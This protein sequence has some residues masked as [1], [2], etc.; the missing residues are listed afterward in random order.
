MRSLRRSLPRPRTTPM[1]TA[2]LTPGEV[3]FLAIKAR[4]LLALRRKQRAIYDLFPD[5]GPLR[6]ELY[7]KHM[8]YF[9]AGALHRERIFMSA[10]RVGKTMAGCYEDAL[11]LT[12]LYDRIAPWWQGRRFEAPIKAWV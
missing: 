2:E 6:R 1:A 4:R 3:R 9:Q 11:H 5:E 12:G 10:N 7:P 8:E